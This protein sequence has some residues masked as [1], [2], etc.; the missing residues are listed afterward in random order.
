MS[1]HISTLQLLHWDDREGFMYRPS[2]DCGW[3]GRPAPKY[4]ACVEWAKH[5]HH[6]TELEKEAG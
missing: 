2:C 4:S 1:D 5:H 3:S 6:I